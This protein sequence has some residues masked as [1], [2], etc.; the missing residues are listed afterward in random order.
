MKNNQIL[1][2]WGSPSS[3]KT[4]TSIKIAKA[5]SVKKKT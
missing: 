3:G 1:G 2:I 5:L 4:V